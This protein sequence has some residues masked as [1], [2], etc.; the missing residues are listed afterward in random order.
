MLFLAQHYI[1]FPFPTLIELAETAVAPSRCA[2]RYS[3][4]SSC[5]VVC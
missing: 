1:A 4:R 5:R 3:S 2:A